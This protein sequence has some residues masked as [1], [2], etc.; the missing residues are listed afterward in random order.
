MVLSLALCGFFFLCA[1]GTAGWLVWDWPYSTRRFLA[2]GLA[3]A[4]AWASAAGIAL[5]TALA[6]WAWGAGFR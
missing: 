4:L 1:L 2:W 3:G 6:E 5:G